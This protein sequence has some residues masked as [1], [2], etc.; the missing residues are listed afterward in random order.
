MTLHVLLCSH[1]GAPFIAQQIA[2]IRAQSRAVDVIHVFD[3]ASEDGTREVLAQL[4]QDASEAPLE[5]HWVDNA[6][7]PALSFFNAM[8]QLAPK[9][10]AG[11]CIFLADQDDVWLPGKVAAMLDAAAGLPQPWA[12][13]HD[14]QVVDEALAPLQPT[15]YTGNPY[16]VPR[17]LDARRLL[18]VNPVIGHT[19]AL[20]G[21]MLACVA[22]LPEPSAYVMHDWAVALVAQRMQRLACVPQCLSLYRQHGA[23]LLGASRQRSLG[24]Q[25]RRGM[26]LAERVLVQSMAW[27]RAQQ[28]GALPGA[29]PAAQVPGWLSMP[30]AGRS[31]VRV[32]LHLAWHALVSGPTRRRRAMGLF[33]VLQALRPSAQGTQ[34]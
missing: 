28:G 12:L 17:D 20:S 4:A 8:A 3:H 31:R 22:R 19:L 32:A 13:F 24:E 34:R 16:A 11:D 26:Q 15:F 2:S 9:V 30:W 23:N 10:G 29:S 14:V 5:L 1:N 21:D 7:G 27:A 6:P 18:L 33:L 25:L